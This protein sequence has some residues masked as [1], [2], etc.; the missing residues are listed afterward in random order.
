MGSLWK[1]ELLGTFEAKS[2]GRVVS[3]FRTRRVASL[4]AYLALHPKRVHTRDEIAELLWPGSDDVSS[5]RN[6]RQALHSLKQ[7]LEPPSIPAGSVLKISQTGISLNQDG[8]ETDT[9]EMEQL[10]AAAKSELAGSRKLE[11]LK[12]AIAFYKGDLLPG[13][14]DLWVMNERFRMED[15]YLSSLK[16]AVKECIG[17]GLIDDAIQFL[18]LAVAKE[19]L[20]EALHKQLVSQYL[21]ANRPRRA[22]EQFEEVAQLLEAELSCQPDSELLALAEKARREMGRSAAGSGTRSA[23]N[24]RANKV[25]A[26][27]EPEPYS[28]IPVPVTRF[29]GR[30]RELAEI[31]G[32]VTNGRTKLLTLLGPAGTGKTRLS[33]EFAHSISQEDW[34]TWFVPLAD[35]NTGGQILDLIMDTVN[36]GRDQARGEVQLKTALNRDRVLVILDNFEH[37]HDSGVEVLVRLRRL[38]PKTVFLVTSRQS[39][40]LEGETQYIIDA[41]PI[42]LKVKNSGITS[43]EDLAELA[44]CP[45][46]QMLVDRCQ[47]IRPDVQITQQ[48]AKHFI[49][50]CEK[51]EGIPLAIEIAAGLSKSSVPSQIVKQLDNR[52]LALASR[53]RDAPPRHQSLRAAIDY[54]F[55][56]L[57]PELRSFFASLSVFKGGFSA[58]SVAKVCRLKGNEQIQSCSKT[59]ADRCLDALLQLQ[60]RSLIQSDLSEEDGAPLRFRMLESFREFGEEQ[61]S[62]SELDQLLQNHAD[63]YVSTQLSEAETKNPE[64]RAKLHAFIKHD[65]NNYIAAADYLLASR[66]I[67]PL[68]KLLVTLSTSW[69]VRGTKDIEKRLIRTVADLPETE[70]APPADRI[71]LYRIHATTYLRNSEFNSAFSWCEKALH[72]AQDVNDK[73]MIAEC[74]F[75]MSLCA[76]Y[77]GQIDHC[78]ALCQEVLK[79]A[80]KSNGVLMERTFV[81]I[82]SAHW[83]RDDFDQAEAAFQ[84]AIEVSKLA[85][86]GEPD[87]LIL[88]HIAGLYLDQKRL[89]AA[90]M[91][92]SEGVRISHRRDDDISLSACLAQISRFHAAKS[93]LPA[94]IATGREALIKVRHV[95][96]SMLCQEVLR[97]FA[98]ILSQADELERAVALIAAT[99]GAESMQKAAERR[100]A[101]SALNKARSRLDKIQ[102]ESAWAK[103][104]AMNLDEAIDFAMAE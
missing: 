55:H 85:R 24:F 26:A 12:S 42:P 59:E 102:Y 16:L 5:R 67:G 36:P 51:L 13:F 90:M 104:L 58:D 4:L 20:D 41:L 53:R 81:S 76:G 18:R 70:N 45:S 68:I 91:A 60:E 93:N 38:L 87:A 95:G 79:H 43:R 23:V 25:D 96:I 78:I 47:S 44:Q 28:S 97:S 19:P 29:F 86:D 92:A 8:I 77:L 56:T 52:L 21:A 10:A 2:R 1:V 54:S 6:L 17:Q 98:I 30:S 88:A 101:D 46:I 73:G 22:L 103:G 49:S 61:L 48:N 100:D 39:L 11:L 32:L 64:A 74:F 57:A 62:E 33:V 83:S 37:I 7:V 99:V 75:G 84:K 14:D 72:V 3:R 9:A 35:I 71:R 80:P 82:G 34:L 63:F 50:I 31:K 94:A 27:A 65:Y 69:D 89:D 40:N 66:R 15:L